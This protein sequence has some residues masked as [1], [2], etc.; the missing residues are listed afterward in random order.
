[1]PEAQDIFFGEYLLV[2][3]HGHIMY[4]LVEF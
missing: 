4:Y 2:R 1:M 3:R